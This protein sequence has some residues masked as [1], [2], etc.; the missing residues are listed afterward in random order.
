STGVTE[1][2]PLSMVMDVAFAVCH[3]RVTASPGLMAFGVAVSDTQLAT[4]G[5]VWM[6]TE[7][8]QCTE[9]EVPVTVAT[10]V[11]SAVRCTAVEP[12]ATGV[13]GPMPWSMLMPVALAVTQVRVTASP[14]LISVALALKTTQEAFSEVGGV[15]TGG[16]MITGGITMT[17]GVTTTGVTGV[18]GV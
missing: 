14:G 6:C 4:G 17:G 11:V 18:S 10:Y 16:V 12:E 8:W 7:A 5:C 1:P 3:A 13:T 15:M 9:V 2:T